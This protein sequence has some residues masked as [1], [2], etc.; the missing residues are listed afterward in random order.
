[1][2]RG[3]KKRVFERISVSLAKGQK[4]GLQ[5]LADEEEMSVADMVRK[6]LDR[7]YGKQLRSRR[8]I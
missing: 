7:A 4:K 6:A 5:K 1:M 3:P 8:S 2:K